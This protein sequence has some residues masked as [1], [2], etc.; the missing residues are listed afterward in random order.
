MCIHINTTDAQHSIQI[1]IDKCDVYLQCLWAR[2]CLPMMFAFPS[3][4][5]SHTAVGFSLVLVRFPPWH[6]CR[7]CGGGAALWSV[8]KEA[9]LKTVLWVVGGLGRGGGQYEMNGGTSFDFLK[10]SVCA[11][12]FENARHSLAGGEKGKCNRDVCVC[13]YVCVLCVYLGLLLL[14]LS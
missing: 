9:R 11:G 13:V 3:E 2:W 10:Q 5:L 8:M 4:E 12:C 7:T 1:D 14:S 6:W